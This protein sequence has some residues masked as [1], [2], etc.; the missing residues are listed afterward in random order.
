MLSSRHSASCYARQISKF[1][2]TEHQHPSTS[3]HQHSPKAHTANNQS[4][5]FQPAFNAPYP[6]PLLLSYVPSTYIHHF[7]R[8]E[9]IERAERTK[10]AKRTKPHFTQ[11]INHQTPRHYGCSPPQHFNTPTPHSTQGINHQIPRH[12]KCSPPQHFNTSTH[13]HLFQS[14]STL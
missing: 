11:G 1:S 2:G 6:P 3:T 5:A 10:R 14:R 9:R 7:K 4:P 13:Q 8:A 12:Y